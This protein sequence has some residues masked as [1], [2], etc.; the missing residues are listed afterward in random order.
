MTGPFDDLQEERNSV[1]K[2]RFER[3]TI[4]AGLITEIDIW[5]QLYH[6]KLQR[7]E[8]GTAELM[9]LGQWVTS[10]MEWHPRFDQ[11]TGRIQ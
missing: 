7:D 2:E 3:V 8:P 4:P 5:L 9:I 11:A 10:L 6:N 1:A